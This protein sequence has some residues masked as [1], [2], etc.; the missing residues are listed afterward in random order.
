M[1]IRSDYAIQFIYNSHVYHVGLRRLM[2]LLERVEIRF[3]K[4]HLV[5]ILSNKS[6]NLEYLV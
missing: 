2:L 6:C 5:S 4:T 3:G 1:K